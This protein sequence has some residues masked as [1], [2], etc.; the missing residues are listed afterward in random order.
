MAWKTVLMNFITT[1][2]V[3]YWFNVLTLSKANE[4]TGM[5][6]CY[7]SLIFDDEMFSLLMREVFNVI[8]KFYI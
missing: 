4:D 6:G 1:Y 7:Y 2:Q 5:S 8:F 3:L